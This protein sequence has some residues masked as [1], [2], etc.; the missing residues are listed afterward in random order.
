VAAEVPARPPVPLSYPKE[1][2]LRLQRDFREVRARGRRR[3][4]SLIVVRVLGTDRGRARL[5]L[6]SPRWYGDAVRRNRF[7]RLVR[8]AFRSVR[9]RLPSVDLLVEP[10]RDRPVPTLEGISRDLLLAAGTPPR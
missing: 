5:G 10:R 7:R 3:S 6:A 1:A 9:A 2:R 4:L 8:E